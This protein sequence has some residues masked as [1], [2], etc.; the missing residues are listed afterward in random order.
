LVAELADGG[1]QSF[2]LVGE[3]VPGGFGLLGS[4]FGLLGSPLGGGQR[5]F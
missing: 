3:C 5:G 2:H 1:L 4:P